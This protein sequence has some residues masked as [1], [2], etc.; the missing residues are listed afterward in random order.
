MIEPCTKCGA[1]GDDHF[2]AWSYGIP[3]VGS[4]KDAPDGRICSESKEEMDK[5][6]LQNEEYRKTL[7]EI[8]ENE[9]PGLDGSSENASGRIARLALEGRS[10]KRECSV[11]DV[12]VY[13]GTQICSLPLPCDIHDRH[14]P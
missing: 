12:P 10:E 11:C 8:Y 13:G 4:Y 9:G 14:K 5:L 2:T 7:K 3:V 1:E 6:K